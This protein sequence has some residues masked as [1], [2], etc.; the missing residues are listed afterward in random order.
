[1]FSV[2][3][4]WLGLWRTRLRL[5]GVAI[6]V[7]GL[8]S[9]LL[10]HPP[11]LLVSDDGRLI[12]LRT[13][14]GA[15]VQQVKGGSKFT[16]DAWA[17]YWAVGGFKPMADDPAGLIRCGT[18][19]CLLKPYPDRPGAMLVRGA[20]HPDGCGQVSVIVS[21]EPARH[22]CPRP[23]PALVDRFTVWRYGSAAIWL[24]PGGAR[25]E[26]DRSARGDRPWVA[27]LPK[28]R[29][30]AAPGLPPATVD[31]GVQPAPPADVPAAPT[32]NGE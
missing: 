4:A 8:A 24:G 10:D 22:L 5:A 7:A 28:P 19:V 23:W 29:A 17:Q 3:L 13:K 15:F 6:M 16:R 27:P 32:S 20:T 18:D 9:P 30:K 21:A 14:E 25:I 2:G 11:D 31:E 1:M 26:T 12:G